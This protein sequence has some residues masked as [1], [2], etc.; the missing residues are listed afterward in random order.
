MTAP[1][2]LDCN[3]RLRLVK[4][5]VKRCARDAPGSKRAAAAKTPAA[6][7]KKPYALAE[8]EALVRE[9]VAT[10]PDLTLPSAKPPNLVRT[11]RSTILG[12]DGCI[13]GSAH[14]SVWLAANLTMPS[15]RTAPRSRGVTGSLNAGDERAPGG[16]QDRRLRAHNCADQ[17]AR[18]AAMP[19]RVQ[20]SA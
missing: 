17:R 18:A 4:S 6:R 13:T 20:S 7:G 14:S 1:R 15:D 2:G 11:S 12:P 8:H 9:L 3:Q 10:Q 19:S 16:A 5:F